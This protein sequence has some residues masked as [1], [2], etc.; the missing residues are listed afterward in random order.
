VILAR[1]WEVL[2]TPLGLPVAVRINLFAATT[3]ALASFFMYLTVHRI[4]VGVLASRRK[5]HVGAAVATL[6]GA[7]SFTVWNQSNVNEKVYT[8]SVL[9]IAA[10]SWLALRWKDRK[11][12]PGSARY[13]LAGLFLLVLG[14]TNHLMSVLPLPAL[15]VFVLLTA[16]GA[17]FRRDFLVR[18]AALVV[19]GLSFNFVLPV[20]S[21]REPVINEGQPT[22]SSLVGAAEA[23]YTNGKAGC[24]ELA[25]NLRRDQYQKPPVTQRMAP[26][27]AQFLNYFQYLDWQW[28]RGMDPS[29][30]PGNA[31]LPITLLFVALA[32]AGLWAVWKTDREAFAYLV[33]LMATLTVG[34]VFY[35]NFKYGYSLA[36]EVQDRTL[37]E[38][39]ERDYFFVASFLF[40]GALAGIGLVWAWDAAARAIKGA[41]GHLALSPILALAL[42]PL[43]FNWAWASRA[44]DYAARDWAYDL[45][46]S[47]EPY[48]II[49][50]NGDN[51]TFPLWYLQEVEGLRQDVTVIV[52]Q[53][54]FTS[55]YPKQ[56]QALTRPER[57]RRFDPAQAAGLYEDPGRIPAHPILALSPEDMDRIGTVRLDRDLTVSLTRGMAVQY[58]A[59]TLLHRG[60]QLAL[61]IIRDSIE[62]RPIYFASSGGMMTELGLT[63]WA[64]NHALGA[65]LV[66][67]KLDGPA[68]EGV[69]R[70]SPEYGGEWFDLDASLKLY[71]D[72]YGYRGIRDRPIWQDRSTL[73]IPWHYYALALQ[74]SDVVRQAGGDE[75]LVD[76]LMQ[77]AA[78]FQI[79][80]QGGARG[81]PAVEPAP[82]PAAEAS[83][84]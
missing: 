68:P 28:A 76:D 26:F 80:A 11:D 20:R 48:G 38:V 50:T 30:T 51:D 8:V 23:I 84:E 67:R 81:R 31:R 25:A 43:A 64:I 61:S 17:V 46:M 3:S 14:S 45:L 52:G 49:F 54:L 33:T 79:V 12:E 6:L 83:P 73:N 9:V 44:G 62:E 21:A 77:D 47:V 5:A 37:H 27:G 55:W 13:L 82:A 35:L 22:C 74:L 72:V 16:P 78:M 42:I 40:W 63:P 59:G 41:R 29:E 10:V 4:L 53:Y 39:R 75:K 71:R 58:P 57:Q 34:L 69:V 19:L 56:L 24:P 36:P 32:G 65:K 7:T 15:G 70:G 18:A 66:M 60:N 2:L 1:T